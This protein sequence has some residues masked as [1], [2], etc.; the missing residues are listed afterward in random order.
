MGFLA[1]RGRWWTALAAVSVTLVVGTTAPRT[2]AT[3]AEPPLLL[4][5]MHGRAEPTPAEEPLPITVDYPLEGSVFPPEF[6]PPTFLWRD[7]SAR[8]RAWT[9]DVSFGDGAAPV[10]ARDVAGRAA[11]EIGEIDPRCRR[12]DERAARS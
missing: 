2:P 12:A 5:P 4:R 8:A 6:P 7:G 3:A 1:S 10:R 9:I 11:C